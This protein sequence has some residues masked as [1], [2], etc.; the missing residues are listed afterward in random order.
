MCRVSSTNRMCQLN[1][2]QHLPSSSTHKLQERSLG[3]QKGNLGGRGLVS[4][5][6]PRIPVGLGMQAGSGTRSPLDLPRVLPKRCH[7]REDNSSSLLMLA[8]RLP[9]AAA[10]N[11][12]LAHRWGLD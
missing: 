3:W 2:S 12:E 5:I 1:F 6:S 4:V 8:V 10:P 9:G 11:P 7:S